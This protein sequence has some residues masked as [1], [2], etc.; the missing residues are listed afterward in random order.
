M[1]AASFFASFGAW[2]PP[3][4]PFLCAFCRVSGAVGASPIDLIA[5]GE[6]H[7]PLRAVDADLPDV[8]V[9]NPR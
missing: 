3:A 1:V 4:V 7:S 2:C 5:V 8:T 9:S 6:E